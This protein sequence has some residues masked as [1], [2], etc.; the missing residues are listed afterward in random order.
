M[1]DAVTYLCNHLRPHQLAIKSSTGYLVHGTGCVERCFLS[2]N[3]I[4]NESPMIQSMGVE[5]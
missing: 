3:E 1:V 4:R 5:K 2:G